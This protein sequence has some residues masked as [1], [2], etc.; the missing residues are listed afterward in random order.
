[1]DKR[2]RPKLSN[3]WEKNYQIYKTYVNKN[4]VLRCPDCKRK[5]LLDRDYKREKCMFR[6]NWCAKFF[7]KPYLKSYT[8]RKKR[9][10]SN[11]EI[12]NRKQLIKV[13]NNY[14]NNKEILST[15]DLR[16][17]AL[18]SALFLTGA[19]ISE[20][21]G[22]P[23]EGRSEIKEVYEEKHWLS[24]PLTKGD[25]ELTEKLIRFNNLNVLKKKLKRRLSFKGFEVKTNKYRDVA[26]PTEYETFF[27]ELLLDYIKKLPDNEDYI[28]F[29]IGRERAW[30]IIRTQFED[31]F[32]HF[33][34]HIR[35]SDLSKFYELSE[36]SINRFFEW[37]PKSGNAGRYIHVK[38]DEIL[39]VMCKNR[40]EKIES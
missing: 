28:I 37:A 11:E 34:R 9:K 31:T 26:L 38:G 35:A 32:C 16:N 25:I 23:R 6:C 2:G 15:Y 5:I 13:I 17:M 24:K 21:L 19:R 18:V 33:F 39:A 30:Q 22:I 20:I 36:A 12:W 4:Y 1:M 40:E 8:F 3:G 27:V 14:R 29:N 10:V 7:T